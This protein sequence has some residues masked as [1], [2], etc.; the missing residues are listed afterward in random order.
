MESMYK[1]HMGQSQREVGSRVGGG[2]GWGGVGSGGGKM[3]TTI[4]EQQ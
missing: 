1:G 3:E 2:D 4:L